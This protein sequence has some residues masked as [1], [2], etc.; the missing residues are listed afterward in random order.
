ME[1]LPSPKK[2][3]RVGR[4]DRLS[5]SD[6]ML[7]AGLVMMMDGRSEEPLKNEAAF[8]KG[9]GMGRNVEAGPVV[10]MEEEA[11]EGDEE[12]DPCLAVFKGAG[13]SGDGI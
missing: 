13:R 6:M 1:C 12:A 2:F 10:L 8:D 11:S 3:F 5:L 9:G 7:V 4:K